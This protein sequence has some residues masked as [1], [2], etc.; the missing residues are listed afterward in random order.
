MSD[1]ISKSLSSKIVCK[2]LEVTRLDSEGKEV[3]RYHL[4]LLTKFTR[5]PYRG[6]SLRVVAFSDWRVQDIG[7]LIRFIRAQKK[8]D[9]ILYAG[10]DIRRF[11]PARK[12]H[13]K[14]IAKLSRFGLCA[15]AGNDDPADTRKLITGRNV[16]PVHSCALVLGPFAILGA[17]GAPLSKE[18]G[19]NYNLGHLLYP[20]RVLALHMGRWNAREFQQKKLIIVSHTPPYGVLDF[21]VRFGP[22]KIGSRPLRAFLE[23]SSNS[24]LCVCGHVHRCGGQTDRIGMTLVVNAASHDSPG[25]SGRVA[26]IRIGADDS[27]NVQWHLI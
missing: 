9:L 6:T 8:P 3:S 19:P 24:L 1:G 10:D 13:F 12:N 26:I 18:L 2:G 14:E 25:E 7:A 22:R 11:R 20:E 15:V 23:S 17:D 5:I 21:A 27:A 16:Y 4:E